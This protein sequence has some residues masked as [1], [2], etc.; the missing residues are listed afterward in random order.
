MVTAILESFGGRALLVIVGL[1]LLG[2]LLFNIQTCASQSAVS[3]TAEEYAKEVSRVK[4]DA[5]QNKVVELE[6]KLETVE[7]PKTTSG[8]LNILKPKPKD[9]PAELKEEVEQLN[10]IGS[11]FEKHEKK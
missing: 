6:K 7:T 2:L 3:K 4:E 1:L 9:V 10:A 8:F 5:M 11:E